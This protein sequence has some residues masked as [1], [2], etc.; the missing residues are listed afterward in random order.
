MNAQIESLLAALHEERLWDYRRLLERAGELIALAHAA[1]AAPALAMANYYTAYARLRLGEPTLARGAALKALSA[2]RQHHLDVE[3]GY[4]LD[5]LARVHAE[6]A[7]TDEAMS[8]ALRQLQIAEQWSHPYLR[9]S[10]LLHMGTIHLELAQLDQALPVLEE[11]SSLARTEQFPDIEVAALLRQA[12]AQTQMSHDDVAFALCQQALQ[13][14]EAHRVD[15][16]RIT[17]RS[18]MAMRFYAR[19][20]KHNAYRLLDEAHHIAQKS[21]SAHESDI[22]HRLGT[23]RWRDGHVNEAIATLIRA[24]EVARR[25]GHRAL[26]RDC[27]HLLGDIYEARGDYERALSYLK[28]YQV[29]HEQVASETVLARVQTLQ[30]IHEVDKLRETTEI[31]RMELDTATRELQAYQQS[32]RMRIERERLRIVLDK[33]R[34]LSDLKRRILYRIHHEFR[35]PLTVVRTSIEMLMRFQERLSPAQ[36]ARSVERIQHQFDVIDRHLR[37]VSLV[38]DGTEV[39]TIAHMQ[40]EQF[41]ALCEHAVQTAYR[42]TGTLGRV[43]EEIIFNTAPVPMVA[44]AVEEIVIELV[45]NA[46][47]FSTGQVQLHTFVSSQQV[48]ITVEDTG[49]GI[50]EAEQAKV[51]EPLYRASNSGA[52]VRGSGLGLALVRDLVELLGGIVT[53]TSGLGKGTHVHVLL[54]LPQLEP[55]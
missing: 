12:D 20:D 13:V 9:A 14:A 55:L 49:I 10:A 26:I 22:L 39:E 52:D 30:T 43:T 33:E 17:A 42:Q 50:P 45:T 6:L 51:F 18:R 46:L 32:E 3:E 35:T 8:A 5:T 44:H 21:Q 29:L 37:T 4:A 25:Y 28:Q 36:R 16:G 11:A 47:K 38:V 48:E 40:R 24:V 34:E 53:L 19:A 23:L 31:Q 27:L 1:D 54:L 2:A 7:Q 41:V 15:E